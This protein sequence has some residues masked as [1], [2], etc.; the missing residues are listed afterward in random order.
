M[1][2]IEYAHALRPSVEWLERSGRLMLDTAE[3]AE[4]LGITRKTMAQLVYTERVPLP[5]RISVGK[6]F[7]WSVLELL[8]WVEAGCPKRSDWIR[9]RGESGWFTH[10]RG[11]RLH[12]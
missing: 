2:K 6:C 7:R 11:S 10:W 5:C 3:M 9:I 1:R 8:E 12:R 4:F